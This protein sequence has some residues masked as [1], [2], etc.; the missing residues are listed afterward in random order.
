MARLIGR[1]FHVSHSVS[2]ATR[3][4]HRIGFTPQVP[5]RPAAGRDEQALA[6]K[7]KRPGRR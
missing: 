6:P 1:T 4:M 2:G 7:R 5:A 3:L